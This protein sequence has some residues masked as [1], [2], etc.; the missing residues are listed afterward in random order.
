LP[1]DMKLKRVCSQF[2]WATLNDDIGRCLLATFGRPEFAS[3]S[4]AI[5]LYSTATEPEVD[6]AS[7]TAP[8]HRPRGPHFTLGGDPGIDQRGGQTILPS[9]SRSISRSIQTRR[10]RNG[11]D[12]PSIRPEP[13][14]SEPELSRR[15]ALPMRSRERRGPPK[16][17][18]HR[19]MR[20]GPPR[21]MGHVLTKSLFFVFSQSP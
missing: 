17:P 19:P 21:G 3:A 6:A 8:D 20:G 9:A 10:V 2:R 1:A 12:Q 18:C 15:K 13:S 16:R 14:R 4:Q 11:P 5:R 7:R